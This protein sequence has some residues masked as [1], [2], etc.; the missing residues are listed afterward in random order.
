MRHASGLTEPGYSRAWP[1]RSTLLHLSLLTSLL[2]TAT[3]HAADKP[4]PRAPERH[5]LWVQTK[6]WNAVLAKHPSAVMLTPE[7]YDALVRDAGKIKPPEPD[8]HLPAKAVI[9]SLRFK[10][11]AADESSASLKLEGE[12]TLRCLT[13]EWTEVT[14]QLPFRNL[15]SAT[16]DGS[17][18]LGLAEE[19]K[20]SPTTQRKLL[21]RGKGTHRITVQVLGKPGTSA[22]ANTR[23]LGFSTTDVPAV[24]D[25]QLPA[26][27]TITSGS[28]SYT[29]EG[30]L[31][32]VLLHSPGGPVLRDLAWTTSS[33]ITQPARQAAA[34]AIAEITDHSIECAWSIT[35]QRSTTDTA[36][37]LVFDV[38]P[39]DAVVLSAEGEGI[40]KWQQNGAQLEV[41]LRDRT[42]TLALS[43]RVRSVI[44]L[45]T[46]SQPHSLALPTV[47][48]AG[49]LA[50]DPQARIGSIAEGVTLMAFE[51]ATPGQNGLIHWNPVRDT[52]KLV[53]RKADPRVVVD[54]D[55]QIR[56]T[57]DDVLIDRTLVVQTDR[58]VT[59][60]RVTL[61]AGEEF[62]STASKAGSTMDWKRSGQSIEYRW[63]QAL[64]VAKPAALTIATRK[65]LA[66]TTAANKLTIESLTI[67][68]AKKLAGYVALDFDPTWRVSVKTASGLEDRD[69]RTTPVRGKM[70]WFALRTF[71]LDFEVQRRDP[72]FDADVTAYALPR[73]KTVEIEGEVVL[74]VSDAPLRQLKIAFDKESAPLVRFTSPLVGEQQLDAA[75]G[76]WSLTLRKESLG[77]VPLR[78]RL[79]LP[80]S[81]SSNGE[82]RTE[83]RE[84][85]TIDAQLPRLTITSARR[86]HGIWV[87]EANTD[88][89][90]T[91]DAKA[92]QPLD[93]LRAPA[94][95]DYQPR[96]RLVA[97]FDYGS[98]DATLT[99]HAAR[100]SHSEL[101][102][103]IVHRLKLLSVLSLDG[104]A[105]HDA[106]FE[107]Q[108]SGEQF[109]NVH[110][111]DQAQLLTA[112]AAGQ[113]VKP[114]RGPDGAISIP[115]PPGSANQPSVPVRLLYETTGTAW[116]SR[117]Q[118]PIDPP[119]LAADIPILDTDWQVY[120]PEGF[121]FPKVDTQLV[122]E[123][124]G[125]KVAG[126]DFMAGGGRPALS[127]E[128]LRRTE[129][130]ET[131]RDHTRSRMLNQVTEGWEERVPVA[132]VALDQ[133]IGL[134]GI[135]SSTYQLEKMKAIRLPSVSF[136]DASV[137]EA[138]E[139]LRMKGRDLDA[140]E[141]DSARQGVNLILKSGTAA[142]TSKITLDLKDV[143]MEEALRYV[144]ELAG[145][146]YKVENNAV[147]IVP[148]ADS[149]TEQ[150]TRTYKVPPDFL[151]LG[152]AASTA[153]AT[154]ADPFAA[155]TE[156]PSSTLAARR[157]AKDILQAQGIPFPD[158]ASAVYNP[159]T[160][161]L[162]V[163]NTASNLDLVESAVQPSGA[164]YDKISPLAGK[165]DDF[166]TT[167]K[168]GLLPLEL[169]L[170]GAGQR[171]HFYGP[172]A[173]TSLVLPYV[174]V[175]RQMLHALFF[176]VIGAA[177]F[178]AW[179]R[180]RVFLRSVLV[181][182][183]FGL[184]ISLLSDD[185][186]PLANAVLVGWFTALILTRLWTLVTAI[187]AGAK[188]A[189]SGLKSSQ[190]ATSVLLHLSLLTSLFIVTNAHAEPPPPADPAAHTVL[191]PFDQSK[192]LANQ[193][194]QRYYLDR[195]DFER[196][197]SLAKENRKPEKVA[198]AD[199]NQ[200]SAVL[201][202]ALYRATIEAER[203]VLVAQ[204]DITSRGR[205][206]KLPLVVK[207]TPA[208]A[209][210]PLR[211]M[212]I[213]GQPGAI[214]NGEVTFEQPGHHVVQATYEVAYKRGW[215]QV[216]LSPPVARAAM[217]SITLPDTDAMPE[218][219]EAKMVAIE[220]TIGGSRVV[221]VGLGSS[222]KL[223]FT[224][225]PRRPVSDAL[226]PSADVTVTTS[227]TGEMRLHS[228]VRSRFIFPGSA[229]KEVA[230][231]LDKNW[232]LD[233]TPA[234]TCGDDAVRDVR[235][236]LKQEGDAPELV[237]SFP[238]DVSNEVT[239]ELHLTPNALNLDHTPFIAPRAAKWE[240]IARLIAQ[241]GVQLNAKPKATQQRLDNETYAYK[242]DAGK[243]SIP[244]VRYR[245]APR[246][247][248][249]F[250]TKPADAKTSA[251]IDY[252]YQLSE[253]KQELAA[254]IALQR[255][256]GE[257]RQLRV[258]LPA[259]MEVQGV[260]SPLLSA[261]ELHGSDLYLRFNDVT[262]K[263]A[264]VVVYVANAVLKPTQNWTLAPLQLS[265]IEKVSGTAIVAAHAAIEARLDGFKGE[266]D[267]REIDPAPLK[268]TFIITPPLEKK[269]AIEFERAA[270]SLK[271]ALQDQPVRFSTDGV[272]L[273]Q[274]TDLG[275]LLSQQ[276][277]VNV[278]QGALKRVVVR[279]PKLLPEATVTGEQLRDM[280]SRVVGE[281]REYEC[282]FQS[283]GGLLGSTALTFDMQLPLT[284]AELK[285]P[286]VEVAD[287][288]RLR[289]FFVLDNSSSRES[290]TLQAD[291]VDTCAKEVLPYV[292]NVLTQPQFYQGR[293]SGG[294]AV[295]F[296]QLQAS[297]GNAAIVTLA[298]ITTVLR[299]D[300]ERWDTV[301]YS[302]SNR[303]LQFLPVI[304]PDKAEL[305]AVTVSGESVRADEE[306][307]KGRRVRLIPLIQ[308][309]AGERS[310]EV[311][312]VY[313]LRGSG[314]PK[315]VKLDDPELV[316]LS[317]ERTV[318]NA[319][320][321]PGWTLSDTARDLYG[322]MEQ[323][324][325]EGRDIEKLQSW[326][327]DLG[328]INRVLSSSKNYDDNNAALAEAEK[329][330]KDI[331]DL[332]QKVQSKRSSR[333]AMTI[334]DEKV[335]KKFEVQTDNDLSKVNEELGKQTL[336]LT[337][338]RKQ[339]NTFAGKQLTLGNGVIGNGW[340]QNTYSGSTTINAGTL[341]VVERGQAL[342]DNVSVANGFFGDI[343]VK[344]GSGT[345]VL[346][347][348]NT[349]TGAVATSGGTLAVGQGSISNV[350]AN[351][352]TANFTSNAMP[353]PVF[354]NSNVFGFSSNARASNVALNEPTIGNV[355]VNG[356]Q[357]QAING[358][359]RAGGNF[360][361]DIAAANS[362]GGSIIVHQ[363]ESVG[364]LQMSSSETLTSGGRT[365]TASSVPGGFANDPV[366]SQGM[367]FGGSAISSDS[368][369]GVIG[370]KNADDKVDMLLREEG[371][372][373]RKQLG[374]APA[375]PKPAAL[376]APMSPADPF[377]SP[378]TPPPAAVALQAAAAKDEMPILQ[379]V[380]K[381]Q[382]VAEPTVRQM[383]AANSA[384]VTTTV[385][386]QLRPTGRRSLQV[387]V[388]LVG[389]TYHFR[390]LKD[391]AVLDLALK[392]ESAPGKVL[393]QT[394]FGA[395]LGAWALMAV[396]ARRRKRS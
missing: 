129:D 76:V 354:N 290:K 275:I 130:F 20:D 207:D 12:L 177:L 58:P 340:A 135:D 125:I 386:N 63:S 359:Q 45:Q 229:R 253:Q 138:I 108:H 242:A 41:T 350:T 126:T 116:S 60:L 17:V 146:K 164:S 371:E 187:E 365:L 148:V 202:S 343:V 345:M 330:N 100:H 316:G 84:Q 223:H 49:Q 107:V 306:A 144:T 95:S 134:S 376:P 325:E 210:L 220:E 268:A 346:S 6:D 329:L 368:G 145:M 38:V 65:R 233:G 156:K 204:F 191:I 278:E 128:H 364:S 133:A 297:S 288:E 121:H 355:T 358:A 89:E 323:I 15:A 142:S 2:F 308:T 123:G 300:G 291:G 385:V 334:Q 357:L 160:G 336:V 199:D 109:I 157:G 140:L 373:A 281:Q 24:L 36:N 83:N 234:V 243:T 235:V 77:R 295:A 317:A 353:Q 381:A 261:W 161:Q 267:L 92:M 176:L 94:I 366:P 103:L 64:D 257:W 147:V 179:G 262:G 384:Y 361:G 247:T 356:G 320:L 294:L 250:D 174:S 97:A 352:S 322:N 321:P 312:L 375:A 269:R 252:V 71:S 314:L 342:N 230:L 349:Y 374:L 165:G 152:D 338:N 260:H 208:N 37:T 391:H 265:D 299:S 379:E 200:P 69:A 120:A 168:S 132:S 141:S 143:P 274:A 315:Q 333:Y 114:V 246:E 203:F 189:A 221:T 286:F 87:I 206:A 96:Y 186:Q 131:A 324:A 149:T 44:D 173:P 172:Q 301:V 80:S 169:D 313:R 327:S 370:A 25:L 318:W 55:A 293:P 390:K 198:D 4:Q 360:S 283:Q 27:A 119:T 166:K 392:R 57:H 31:A 231:A 183:V 26:G 380:S 277:A 219:S 101:A 167:T 196:L 39:A 258:T 47:R 347:G 244:V 106:T 70:A 280:Q 35:I 105:R 88:T 93:V 40:T 228:V 98:T 296:T 237:A 305:M 43:T 118:R 256:R 226:P 62:L 215:T 298:D 122:Q 393:Q 249:A 240:T 46:D 175:Q 311:K 271:V 193:K 85:G 222:D 182:I 81:T 302:L 28:A 254:A 170:P 201:H 30:D 331:A 7:Q 61:P 363:S 16:V 127:P 335:A 139:F 396:I 54:A 150:F 287:V 90:L 190:V 337:E 86:Q 66:T 18:V 351:S 3:L 9:E 13:D 14:A 284:D 232:T 332:T 111:P 214:A 79:S 367:R 82:P 178:I 383:S 22:L 225:V 51:G 56:V 344:S 117:G 372:E 42:H 99:L 328:R 377:A 289:R 73:A 292:P 78:F 213:D 395:G 348:S 67:P 113:P 1:M 33:A 239:L 279:L 387:E 158:G 162:T 21:V 159:V 339:N 11:S 304:L 205:W 276:L 369:S 255:E 136:K 151:S 266:H 23:S 382:S 236:A 218:F 59:E 192:P 245:L 124:T 272:L 273:A 29:R 309:K 181:V 53:L 307:R 48:F 171:L 185:W 75:T 209:S 154:A 74:H 155:P 34:S 263:L 285:L 389:E 188:E 19:A 102:A 72:V 217:A 251:R 68:E 270:W 326:M 137:E 319:S 110:L 378:A 115:L 303:S 194:P 163:K 153:G 394:M 5:E 238:H 241:D 10:G 184:G 264:K 341:Q 211:E 248:L 32:H 362:S 224:R 388:P 91:F 212:I 282:T 310:M 216:H 197:W 52:L 259:G 8:E 50:V 180:H 227:L 104:S 195:A 112:L